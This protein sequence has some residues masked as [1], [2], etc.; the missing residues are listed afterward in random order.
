MPDSF[1]DTNTLIYL[2]SDDDLKA[3]RAESLLSG[4]AM[5]SVQVLNEIANVTRRKLKWSWQD[6]NE[7]L[8]MVRE[9]VNVQPMTLETHETGLELCQRYGFS[10]YDGLIV[11]SALLARCSTLWSEDMQ[12][13]LMIADSL[14]IRNPFTDA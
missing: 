3:N 12:D 7:F 13:G 8:A 14:R 1:L 9:F 4:G 11:A 2:A 10:I 5:I 6:T